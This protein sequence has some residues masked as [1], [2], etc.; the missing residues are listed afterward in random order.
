MSKNA[1]KST[2]GK[3]INVPHN[4]NSDRAVQAVQMS[5]AHLQGMAKPEPFTASVTE[6]PTI[7]R[8]GA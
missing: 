7:N 5:R 6:S 2:A 4:S 1:R 3:D 8:K